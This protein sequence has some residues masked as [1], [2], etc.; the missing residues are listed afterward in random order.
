MSKH[1]DPRRRFL[2]QMLAAGSGA[3]LPGLLLA[4]Q[5]Q[6]SLLEGDVLVNGR[7]I[8][9]SSTIKSGDVIE[10]GESSKLIFVMDEDA[11]LLR[12]NT[13]ISIAR[14]GLLNSFRVLTG[15]MLAV[16][17]P[18]ARKVYTP[19]VTAGIRG[20]GVYIEADAERS[21][22][23]TCYGE[24]ELVSTVNEAVREIVKP[25]EQSGFHIAR[26]YYAAGSDKKVSEV[27]PM[28]GHK[29]AELALCES[30]VGRTAPF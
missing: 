28:I 23:C 4:K 24:V 26:Y 13:R 20:T 25:D 2:V 10:T 8:D 30:L 22:F 12:G 29:D 19:T 11:V 17:S 3:T 7:R 15:K 6:I 9:A 21:Y 18:G 5:K 27:A 14:N 1:N 16:F